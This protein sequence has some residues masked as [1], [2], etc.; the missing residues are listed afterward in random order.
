MRRKE[1]R[2]RRRRGGERDVNKFYNLIRFH[3]MQHT[4][5][6]THATP[7]TKNSRTSTHTH[8]Q[9]VGTDTCTARQELVWQFPKLVRC[10]SEA[11]TR[12]EPRFSTAAS[13]AASTA[14]STAA[15]EEWRAVGGQAVS[16]PLH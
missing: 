6:P 3:S 11:E 10:T 4:H 9:G 5:I 8:A 14:G 7:D 1:K 16:V 12:V 13:T 2:R 15:S